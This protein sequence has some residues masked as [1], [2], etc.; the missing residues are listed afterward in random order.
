[1]NKLG[2]MIRK[3]GDK[4]PPNKKELTK[5]IKTTHR[6][7]KKDGVSITEFSI[8]KD[9]FG[10][11]YHSHLLLTLNEH[12]N[13]IPVYKRLSKY[14]QGFNINGN[15]WNKELR[16]LEYFDVCEGKYG[17]IHIQQIRNENEYRGY[18]NKFGELLTLI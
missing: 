1:M 16:G 12:Q 13:P 18:I 11:H 14:I 17:I 2:I 10:N 8:E 6:K 3:T 15:L 9:R 7:L 5:Q 4:Y